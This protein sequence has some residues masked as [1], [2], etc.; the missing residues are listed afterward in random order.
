MPLAIR[1]F[2]LALAGGLAGAALAWLLGLTQGLA[3]AGPGLAEA[4][5]MTL[6]FVWVPV[7]AVIG[8]LV[9][10]LGGAIWALLRP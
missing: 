2:L 7:G 10:V 3:T 1:M 4:G 5:A 6:H 8:A 9:A